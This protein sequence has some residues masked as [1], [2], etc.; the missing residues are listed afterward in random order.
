MF[1]K[2]CLQCGNR[3]YIQSRLDTILVHSLEEDKWTTLDLP[4]RY[5]SDHQDLWYW[6]GRIFAVTCDEGVMLWG[7]AYADEEWI[8]PLLWVWVL[9]DQGEE[10]R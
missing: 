8:P 4:H 6:Q 3:M 10:M 5:A 9:V 2:T 7:R 1:P